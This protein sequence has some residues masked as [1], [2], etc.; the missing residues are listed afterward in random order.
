MTT[1]VRVA[2]AGV[3][4]CT[5]ALVQGRQLYL[6]THEYP[7]GLPNIEMVRAAE[8]TDF[9]AAFDVDAR[10]VGLDLADAI[11]TE[12]NNCPPM[13]EVPPMDVTVAP[14]C[15]DDGVGETLAR[16]VP[17]LSRTSV[18]EVAERLR[19]S[20]AELL[21]NLLP[22]GSEQATAA[23]AEAAL[24]AG[25]GFVNVSS[26]TLAREN[27]WQ[28][29]FAA[30]GLVLVGDDLKAQLGA[31]IV[32]QTL[33]RLLSEQGVTLRDTYQINAGGNTNFVNLSD[34]ARSASKAGTK[35]RAVTALANNGAGVPAEQT[36][37]GM[38]DYIP[39][40]GDRKVAYIRM[41][42]ETF[43]RLPVE[44]ELRMDVPDSVNGAG[45]MLDALRLGA[46]AVRNGDPELA[47]AVASLLMKEP[48]AHLPAADAYTRIA[49]AAETG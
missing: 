48:S 17:R 37:F 39:F 33:V 1:P 41:V 6:K 49:Q 32:H 45:A 2:L 29:R 23:Y 11:H 28:E 35:S 22:T 16:H 47:A 34:T 42:G 9:V 43:G 21:L 24:Q 36:Y 5:S 8:S 31:T 38:A 30:R 25:C 15:G 46:L 3:G 18:E 7:G 12:P 13:A 10:K 19:D 20:G 14:G 4:N 27:R 44:L 40:L 26:T